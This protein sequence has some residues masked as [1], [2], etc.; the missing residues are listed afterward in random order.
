MQM[1][2]ITTIILPVLI[3]LMLSF[4]VSENKVQQR[5]WPLIQG[6]WYFVNESV[7]DNVV[8]MHRSGSPFKLVFT[9]LTKDTCI[10]K[11]RGFNDVYKSKKYS[12]KFQHDTL[13]FFSVNDTMTMKLL[14]L[15]NSELKLKSISP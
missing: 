14:L 5:Y 6:K 3:V 10:F 12:Y 11:V 9:F 7:Y 4:K 13:S 1:K 2:K 8:T 15:T